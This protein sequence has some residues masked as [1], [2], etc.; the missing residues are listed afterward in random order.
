MYRAERPSIRNCPTNH[1]YEGAQTL[2]RVGTF[3]PEIE[4]WRV[5][6]ADVEEGVAQ[7]VVVELLLVAEVVVDGRDVGPGAVADV[8]HA[9]VAV[10]LLG[11][12]LGG[13]LE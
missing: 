12:D 10:A 7:H 2:R 6:P 8:T 4:V 3:S 5:V 11:V 9:G 13:G 1:S